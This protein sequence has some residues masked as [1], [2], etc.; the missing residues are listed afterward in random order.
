MVV[1]GWG[2]EVKPEVAV[3]AAVEGRA[4]RRTVVVEQHLDFVLGMFTDSDG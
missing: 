4:D 2:H 1:G 3:L